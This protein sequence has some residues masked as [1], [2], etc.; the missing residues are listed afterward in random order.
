MDNNRDN[1]TKSLGKTKEEEGAQLQL[2][3]MVAEE[4][5]MEVEEDIIIKEEEETLEVIIREIIMDLVGATLEMT[6]IIGIICK[7]QI[8]D[9]QAIIHGTM[10]RKRIHSNRINLEVEVDMGRTTE[11]TLM[12][13]VLEEEITL[14]EVGETLKNKQ[15]IHIREIKVLI[16]GKFTM[17]LR[18]LMFLELLKE[19]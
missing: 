16:T 10:T 7:D 2:N 1:L 14:E 19:I 4:M 8:L 3:S 11:E 13:V 12:V 18:K 6:I 17:L 9:R 5:T 15:I